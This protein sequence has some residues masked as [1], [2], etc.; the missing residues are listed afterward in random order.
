MRERLL[1]LA[2]ACPEVSQKYESLICVAGITAKGEWR[3][4]YPI[5]WKI[6]WGASPK[7]FSKKQWIEYELEDEKPS[8][9]RP[10]SRK[11][12]PNTIRALKRE[13]YGKI[14]KLLAERITTIERL[15]SKGSKTASLGVIKPESIE[16]FF[17][18]TN[19]QYQKSVTKGAQMDLFGKSAV[20]LEIPKYKYKYLFMDDTDGRT[21][22]ILCEDWEV[23]ELYR[24][25]ED[26]R[27]T[28]RYK[29]EDEV[30]QKVKDKMLD[31]TKNGAYFI[32]GSHYRFPTYM[33]IGVIYPTKKDLG[34]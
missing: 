5:P 3:R 23:G 34:D 15:E 10:E 20:K 19:R 16:D 24:N 9:H 27:K 21:H 1:V 30:H 22:E 33:I 7:N 14:E 32:M 11:I 25:C 2:K 17:P 31:I 4:I 29:D 13:E 8:D 12:K 28:G 6:F 18:I 26:Y